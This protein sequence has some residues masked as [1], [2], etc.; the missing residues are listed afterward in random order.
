MLRTL[1]PIQRVDSIGGNRYEAVDHGDGK[2]K[3]AGRR[4][5]SDYFAA[6]E[7]ESA[8]TADLPGLPLRCPYFILHGV[9]RLQLLS[10]GLQYPFCDS[11]ACRFGGSLGT[12]HS[13][14]G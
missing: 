4:R 6:L 13:G 8:Q 1:Y 9:D 10:G 14:R 3:K 2:S 7:T 5:S 11:C 12:G